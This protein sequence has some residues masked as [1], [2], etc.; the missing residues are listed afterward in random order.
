MNITARVEGLD[1]LSLKVKY[2]S[3]AAALGLKEGTS[4]AA[5][6]FEQEAKLLVPVDTGRLR[7]AIHTD[8]TLDTPEVQQFTVTPAYDASNEYGFDP[9]YARRIELG[10]IGTDSLGRNYHQAAQQFMAPAFETKKAEA[11]EAVKNGVYQRV[12]A[13]VGRAA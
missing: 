5:G 7:D 8:H 1:A 12:D 2:M 11:L 6:I 10:F 13:A 3:N 9:P 4:E